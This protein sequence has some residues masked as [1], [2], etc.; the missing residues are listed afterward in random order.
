L[1]NKKLSKYEVYLKLNKAIFR[2]YFQL[3]VKNG[4]KNQN[5]YLFQFN[6]TNIYEFNLSLTI[7]KFLFF[8]KAI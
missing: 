6:F 1:W 7:F 3:K 5:K 4:E 2:K 8:S